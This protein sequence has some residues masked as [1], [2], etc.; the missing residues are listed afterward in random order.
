MR[1]VVAAPLGSRKPPLGAGGRGEGLLPGCPRQGWALPPASPGLSL[2]AGP[3]EAN[4]QVVPG[5]KVAPTGRDLA[6]FLGKPWKGQAVVEQLPLVTWG[7]GESRQR[8]LGAAPAPSCPNPS[9]PGVQEGSRG[10]A[11]CPPVPAPH[12]PCPS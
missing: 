4:S 3:G 8:V 11:P 12:A 1:K 2:G 6:L 7:E 10:S 5:G 9:R